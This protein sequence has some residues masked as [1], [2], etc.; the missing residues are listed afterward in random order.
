MAAQ[1]RD[2][3]I[4]RLRVCKKAFNI[5]LQIQY[6]TNTQGI[7]EADAALIMSGSGIAEA[8]CS[9][10]ISFIGNVIEHFV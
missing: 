1:P 4:L 8:A 10:I 3:L 5:Y 6:M 7:A 9:F 2:P